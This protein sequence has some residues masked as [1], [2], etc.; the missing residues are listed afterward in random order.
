VNAAADQIR[1]RATLVLGLLLPHSFFESW[2]WLAGPCFRLADA[3]TAPSG[4]LAEVI[5]GRFQAHVDIVPN[6]LDSMVV[7][8]G[9]GGDIQDPRDAILAAGRFLAAAGAARSESGALY[10]YNP[11]RLYVTA[12]SRYARILRRDPLAFEALYASGAPAN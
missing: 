9:G 6:L 10:R 8:W 11:S 1:S 2:G 7:R 5:Q 12:V 3:I 4:F